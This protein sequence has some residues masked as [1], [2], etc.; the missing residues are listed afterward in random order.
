VTVDGLPPGDWAE[1]VS[2]VGTVLAF[3][4]TSAAFWQGPRLHRVEHA[5]AMWDDA[6]RVTAGVAQGSKDVEVVGM[7]DGMPTLKTES[8]VNVH[9]NNGSRRQIT[10]IV[11]HVTTYDAAVVDDESTLVGDGS[12][13]FIQANDGFLF[14]FDSVDGVWTSAGVAAL[15]T[16]SFEDIAETRWERHWSGRLRRFRRLRRT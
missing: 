7:K 1:W 11:V 2:G 4:A 12:V 8:K 10:N 13:E 9:I 6:L 14:V 15:V 3:G 5:E 16:F